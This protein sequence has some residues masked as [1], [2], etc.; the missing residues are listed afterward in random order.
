MNT[1]TDRPPA[2]PLSANPLT[3][4]LARGGF[5]FATQTLLA[6][7]G[8]LFLALVLYIAFWLPAGAEAV[9]GAAPPWDGGAV[10]LVFLGWLSLAA[11]EQVGWR[12]AVRGV[13]AGR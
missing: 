3:T 5:R 4:V 12:L 13:R 10:A 2:T 1:P 6:V 11:L 8:V 9:G 7:L